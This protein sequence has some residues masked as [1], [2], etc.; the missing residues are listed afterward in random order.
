MAKSY[1]H[2]RDFAFF[3]VNFGTS[4]Q[5]FLSMTEVEKAF[6]R[7]EY[8]TKTVFEMTQ[9]RDAF[10]N[11]YANANRGKNRKFQDLY[12]KKQSKADVEYNMN[13]VETIMKI[14]KR[15]GKSWVDKIYRAVKG[16]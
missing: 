6:I 8:E 3:H 7:K 1:S 10:F 15:D 16:R 13:A 4:K 9:F 12:K 14:E 2:E 5:D 11:A